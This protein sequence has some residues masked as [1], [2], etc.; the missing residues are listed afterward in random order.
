MRVLYIYVYP[1]QCDD[2]GEGDDD[3]DADADGSMKDGEDGSLDLIRAPY[4][5][6]G[7]EYMAPAAPTAHIKFSLDGG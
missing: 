2:E 3:A 6:H 1:L 5:L 7:V 4:V